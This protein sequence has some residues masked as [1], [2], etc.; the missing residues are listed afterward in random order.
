MSDITQLTPESK[1]EPG[2]GLEAEGEAYQAA[3]AVQRPGGS[4]ASTRC[5]RVKED[6]SIGNRRRK[7][8]LIDQATNPLVVGKQI[9][10]PLTSSLYVPGK[11]SDVD[12]HRLDV[13]HLA[14][15]VERGGERD[16]NLLAYG[17]R[18]QWRDQ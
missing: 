9:L 7:T 1:G 3:F 18:C 2:S 8:D 15:D 12:D 6:P 10:V 16:E 13:A 14:R 17:S 5:V 11:M 4:S